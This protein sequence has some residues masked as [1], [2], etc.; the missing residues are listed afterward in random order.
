[1]TAKDTSDLERTLKG[2]TSPI[3]AI[4][5]IVSENT[6]ETTRG[7]IP[8]VKIPEQGQKLIALIKKILET[9]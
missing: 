6:I 5:G 8:I 1:L 4:T 9:K 7:G 2:T 3:L